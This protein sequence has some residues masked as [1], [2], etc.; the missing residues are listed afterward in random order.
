[1]KKMLAFFIVLFMMLIIFLQVGSLHVNA[2]SRRIIT[3]KEVPSNDE[4]INK[5]TWQKQWS[6]SLQYQSESGSPLNG[7]TLFLQERRDGTWRHMAEIYLK[8]YLP[9]GVFHFSY[10]FNYYFETADTSTDYLRMYVYSENDAD[11]ILV[12]SDDTATAYGSYNQLSISG[13]INKESYA[14]TDSLN[15]KITAG[16]V[17][18]L[19]TNSF[20]YDFVI[21]ESDANTYITYYAKERAFSS[22]YVFTDGRYDVYEFELDTLGGTYY[23]YRWFND[24]SAWFR[25]AYPLQENSYYNRT[26][27]WLTLREGH[28]IIQVNFVRGTGNIN[29]GPTPLPAGE[30]LVIGPQIFPEKS[31]VG[32]TRYYVTLGTAYTWGAI[33]YTSSTKLYDSHR[34]RYA[35]LRYNPD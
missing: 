4:S 3:L 17:A 7:Y 23:L 8:I 26:H 16:V 27:H 24:E 21:T 1:M 20:Y 15:I 34:Y 12:T 2:D 13:S 14:K 19:S 5:V 35:I 32:F 6:D 31:N 18:D 11:W 30:R 22:R 25:R 10:Y 33:Y 28:Y 29:D 9:R